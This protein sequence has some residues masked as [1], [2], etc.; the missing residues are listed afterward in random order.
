MTESQR[1]PQGPKL[2]ARR[3][4][5]K[6]TNMLP[7]GA[8]ARRVRLKVVS[9]VSLSKHGQTFCTSPHPD[10][11]TGT[12]SVR[13]QVSEWERCKG[14][15]RPF[16]SSVA[17]KS[18]KAAKTRAHPKPYPRSTRK[19]TSHIQLPMRLY[20]VDNDP[21]HPIAVLMG[22]RATNEIMARSTL[23]ILALGASV[24]NIST[25]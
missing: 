11:E 14:K 18:R 23:F 12:R 15:P 4:R 9:L 16:P 10:V 13:R 20:R 24:A 3:M 7:G 6:M 21:L 1:S 8:R 5:I 2:E 19:Y 25:S 22:R 17:Q